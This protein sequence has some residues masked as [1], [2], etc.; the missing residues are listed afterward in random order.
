M[1]VLLI[2]IDTLRADRLGCYGH[3]RPTSPHIDAVAEKGVLFEEFIAPHIPT[4]PG[5]TTIF[6]GRDAFDHQVVAQGGKK[7]PPEGVRFLPEILTDHGYF[8]AAADNMGRWFDRGYDVY[9][10]FHW[11]RDTSKPWRKAEAVN[12]TAFEI[13]KACD[14]QDKPWFAFVHYWDPHTPYLPPPPFDRMFYCGDETDPSKSSA[15]PMMKGYPAFDSYFAD[16]M[17]GLTDI[18]FPKMQYD[19]EIAYCDTALAHIFTCL[20]HME[21]AEDTLIIITSDHGEELDEHEMYFDH[22]GLYETN[23]HVPLIIFHP[24][25]FSGGRRIGG[26]T[27]HQDLAPTILH[28]LGMPDAADEAHMQGTSLLDYAAADTHEG[29]REFAYISECSWMKKRGIRTEKHKFFESLYDELHHRPK[30]EL[31]NL[32]EDPLEEDNIADRAS[33]L[34]GNFL[35]T[36]T[37]YVDTRLGETGQPDPIMEQEITLTRVGNVNV[38]VPDN[39]ILEQ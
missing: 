5:F 24:E 26:M 27:V 14:A 37:D 21:G 31:Y 34:V 38:A 10:N 12:E 36:M 20:Q 25:L 17:P 39:Q 15:E 16:W 4:H 23:M 18:E 33:D 2:A 3:H 6:S 8:T 11:V 29:T 7:E 28:A 35:E 30:Y 22:H 19:A 32:Q 13:L 9:E 1:N